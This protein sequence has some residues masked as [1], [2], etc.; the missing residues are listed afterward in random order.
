M[1]VS[2]VICVV[3]LYIA[4]AFGCAHDPSDTNDCSP[5]HCN[6]CEYCCKSYLT[7]T[8]NVC[9]ICVSTEC[10]HAGDHGGGHG[11]MSLVRFTCNEVSRRLLGVG[12]TSTL[13][14]PSHVLTLLTHNA[15][16]SRSFA[17]HYYNEMATLFLMGEEGAIKQ[18]YS[19]DSVKEM[20]FHKETLLVFLP[21]YLLMAGFCGGLALPFGTFVPNL[22][23]GAA[24]GRLFAVVTQSSMGITGLSSPGTYALIGAGSVLGGYV[25][26]R[27]LGEG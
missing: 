11:G 9:D 26:D 17:Q 19:R 3:P 20:L 22:F 25:S 14:P 6:T 15:R 16:Y 12:V 4:N 13:A 18:L 24:F 23:M 2:C 1:L 8:Q 5:N 27:R 21:I 7:T 10:S